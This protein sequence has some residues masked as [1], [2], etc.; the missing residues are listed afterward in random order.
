MN[1]IKIW[2]FAVI[3]VIFSFVLGALL[4]K[5]A[6]FLRNKN[7]SLMNNLTLTDIIVVFLSLVLSIAIP[8]FMIK[9]RYGKYA[10]IHFGRRTVLIL[11]A[12][13]IIS[14]LFF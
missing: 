1:S 10:A 6:G 4:Q 3:S 14:M 11:I 5:I 13:W 7:V 12:A 9:K 2:F 8:Y